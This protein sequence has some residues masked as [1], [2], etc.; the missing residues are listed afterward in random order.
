MYSSALH[1]PNQSK[2]DGFLNNSSMH[3]KLA[4]PRLA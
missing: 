4:T 3:R 2:V 1:R